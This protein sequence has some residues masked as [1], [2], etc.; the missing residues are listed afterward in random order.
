MGPIMKNLNVF[1]L[2][3]NDHLVQ[4]EHF[5]D[6]QATTPARAIFTDFRKHKPHMLDSHLEASEAL[7]VM[8]A[9]DVFTKLVVD[10][11]K[12]FV[13]VISQDDLAEH[14]LQLKQMALLVKRD[15]LLVRDLM[16]PRANIRAISYDQLL[17]ATLADVVATMKKNHQEYLLVVD[18][19]AHH[20]RGV[21]SAREIGRRLNMPV[22]IEKELT[23]AD[24][25]TAVKVH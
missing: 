13:G 17:Q 9:E 18:P 7:E 23:F 3:A 5:T 21:I 11:R 22:D 19:E 6:V 1:T 20:I 12:E 2:A 16:H 25:F 15:E 24:I 10:D 14:N 8:S 4:P